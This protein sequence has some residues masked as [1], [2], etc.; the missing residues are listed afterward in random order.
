VAATLLLAREITFAMELRRGT[1][2]IVLDGNDVGAIERHQTI[3][4]PIEPG[5]HRLQVKE[6]RYASGLRTFDVADGQIVNFRCNG[7]RI[8][9]VYLA[10]FVKP[11]LALRL[12]CA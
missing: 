7:A 2:R 12:D 8:W 1:F 10:S 5:R 6:G 3:E 11:D 4:M 9:P